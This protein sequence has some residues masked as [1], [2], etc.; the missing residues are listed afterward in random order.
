MKLVIWLSL[1]LF[2]LGSVLFLFQENIFNLRGSTIRDIAETNVDESSLSAAK[3]MASAMKRTL[4]IEDRKIGY[5]VKGLE[6]KEI[7]NKKANA[8]TA[9]VLLNYTSSNPL[10]SMVRIINQNLEILYSTS[11]KDILGSTLKRVIYQHVFNPYS[12]S[13]I[14]VIVD[15]VMESLV[16]FKKTSSTGI[17]EAG[18]LFYYS[19][20]LFDEIFKHITDIQYQGFLITP[21]KLVLV[22]FPEIE[23]NEE[24]NLNRF[25]PVITERN[26]GAVRFQM[27]DVDKTVYF[28]RLSNPVNEWMVGV[29]RDTERF[30]LSNTGILILSFQVLVIFSIFIFI[31]ISIRSKKRLIVREE[32]PLEKVPLEKKEGEVVSE[33]VYIENEQEVEV[34]QN[35][36]TASFLLGKETDEEG[37]FPFTER[38]VSLK[39]VEE[40]TEL[41]E[42]GEAEIAEEIEELEEAEEELLPEE[43]PGEETGFI[44][45]N[46]KQG[47]REEEGEKLYPEEKEEVL[48]FEKRKELMK[49]KTSEVF[50]DRHNQIEDFEELVEKDIPEGIESGGGD[51]HLPELD[52]LV[53]AK[54]NKVKTKFLSETPPVIPEEIYKKVESAKKDDELARLIRSI[55]NGELKAHKAHDKVVQIFNGFM[56]IMG[57]SRGAVLVKNKD[58]SFLPLVNA[59]LSI[60]TE[61]RLI[62]T[63]KERIFS[64]FLEQGKIVHI[65]ENVFFNHEL[66]NK[67]D[68]VDSGKIKQLYLVPL[69]LGGGICGIVIICL[70]ISEAIDSKIKLKE[71]KS[72]QSKLSIYI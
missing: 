13:E 69:I 16:F 44:D 21:E 55:E 54:V 47:E 2:I 8:G 6:I 31:I 25:I 57:L 56:K 65:R 23:I 19:Q 15:P 33:E 10:C 46:L 66:R 38:T 60:E 34:K 27:N 17:G 70:T 11:R 67:F 53:K 45:E 35:V 14:Q 58:G 52:K 50:I 12:L 41:E 20:A 48:P 68:V 5:I 32:Q 24:Q 29:A 9:S 59:G 22:N 62:F 61:K 26:S 72:L 63:G 40:L 7:L 28:Q 18:I 37:V 64:T 30:R 3:H 39:D 42:I 51:Y 36:E 71:I 43:Q 1:S 49:D 4:L